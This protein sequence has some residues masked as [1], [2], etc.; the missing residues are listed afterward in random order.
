MSAEAGAVRVL[1]GRAVVLIG[2]LVA[3]F[4]AAVVLVM[5]RGGDD[6]AGGAGTSDPGG[7]AEEHAGHTVACDTRAPTDPVPGPAEQ[8]ELDAELADAAAVVAAT[9]TVADAEA[10]GF[11]LATGPHCSGVH[12]IHWDRMDG[13]L[14]RAAPEMLLA[15]GQEPDDPVIG[16]SYYE[17]GDGPE[18]DLYAGGLDRFHRHDG[19][20]IAEDG[21]VLGQGIAAGDCTAR[22][23]RSGDDGWMLHVWPVAG[24]ENPNGTFALTTSRL[25]EDGRTV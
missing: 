17:V 3:L 5:V 21:L 4:A 18:P 2:V 10:A 22:G 25:D 6:E 14:D 11:V 12:L 16:L 1:S 19:M 7:T 20:C 15:A 8:E 13:E 24:W 23:G 9:P